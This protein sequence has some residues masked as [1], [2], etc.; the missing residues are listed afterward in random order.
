MRIT[1]VRHTAVDVPPGVCYGRSDVA[2]KPTFPEEAA[3]V[4]TEIERLIADTGVR[5]DAVYRSPLTRCGL[6]AT[7]CAYPDAVTDGRLLEMNFGEWE[8]RRYDE[9]ND[10]RLQKWYDDWIHVTP[11]GGESF[12]DQQRRVAS[13]IE[14]MKNSGK[15]NV[16]VFTHAGVMMNV[17]LLLDMASIENVFSLQPPYGGLLTVDL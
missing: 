16:L 1:F 12:L 2:L 3:N 17:M 6:L 13:F 14:D 9:I 5:F 15:S 10:P 11:P 8:M 7:A 4:R